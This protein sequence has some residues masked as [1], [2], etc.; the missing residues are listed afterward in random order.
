MTITAKAPSHAD[1]QQPLIHGRDRMRRVT[2]A[3]LRN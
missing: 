3:E 1:A 2:R